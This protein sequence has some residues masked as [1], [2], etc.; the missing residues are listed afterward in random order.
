MHMVRG[1]ASLYT[2]SAE[3]R[4]KLREQGLV[5]PDR[6]PSGFISEYRQLML[7]QARFQQTLVEV[8]DTAKGEPRDL[9]AQMTQQPQDV[10]QAGETGQRDE[11]EG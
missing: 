8:A 2:L 5:G 10:E 9:V 11:S 6:Q 3:V 4:R 1:Y 7:A